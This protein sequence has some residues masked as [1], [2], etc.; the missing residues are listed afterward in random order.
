MSD[1]NATAQDWAAS[2]A[3]LAV[4]ALLYAGLVRREQLEIASS[5]I[6]EEIFARLCVRDY[7]PP[8]DCG[9]AGGDDAAPE[10]SRG[11]PD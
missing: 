2:V 8:V 9:R 11:D 4:D 5:I 3:D 10:L 7:P 1:Q 6:A